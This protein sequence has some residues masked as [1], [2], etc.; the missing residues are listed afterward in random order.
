M[1]VALAALLL[2]LAHGQEARPDADLL[3]L[4]PTQSR[5]SAGAGGLSPQEYPFYIND[6]PFLPANVDPRLYKEADSDSFPIMQAPVALSNP[7]WNLISRAGRAY[8]LMR[9]SAQPAEAAPG[10]S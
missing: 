4:T 9:R 2:G 3:Y 10:L 5:V 8:R 7:I 6:Y 1:I